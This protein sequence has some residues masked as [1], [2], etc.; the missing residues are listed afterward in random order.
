MAIVRPTRRTRRDPAPRVDSGESSPLDIIPVKEEKLKETETNP[1]PMDLSASKAPLAREQ[2][3]DEPI[4]VSLKD[5]K[6]HSANRSYAVRVKVG[7]T[8][9]LRKRGI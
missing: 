2:E 1:I 6:S 8:K 4:Y 9:V 5:V 3:V 7:E